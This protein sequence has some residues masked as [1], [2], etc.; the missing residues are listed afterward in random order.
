MVESNIEKRLSK[1]VDSAVDYISIWAK[2]RLDEW[3]LDA[4][5]PVIT[6]T[7]S[8]LQIGHYQL[9]RSGDRWERRSPSEQGGELYF[10]KNIAVIHT[11]FEF[12]GRRKL[13]D[14][15]LQHNNRICKLTT[16]LLHYK[17]GKTRA[18]KKDNYNLADAF[19]ARINLA[20][21]QIDSSWFQLQKTLG[22][23]KYIKIWK[24]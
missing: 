19:D 7:D 1:Q 18:L 22:L 14:D 8:G 5:N 12:T 10:N 17:N 20:Q 9:L 13:A 23:T 6:K 4:R 3:R 2:Q 24:D 11:L 16:D 21:S 15:I